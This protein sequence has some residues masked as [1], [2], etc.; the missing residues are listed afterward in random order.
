MTKH[1]KVA[2]TEKKLANGNRRFLRVQWAGSVP[3]FPE[4]IK[5]WNMGRKG[6]F[7]VFLLKALD[8]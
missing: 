7:L 6:V 8:S 2:E 3:T 5:A 4:G 1:G